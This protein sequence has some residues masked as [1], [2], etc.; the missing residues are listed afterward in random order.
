MVG[1]LRFHGTFQRYFDYIVTGNCPFYKIRPVAGQPRPWEAIG[2]WRVAPT[3]TRAMGRPKTPLTSLPSKG[4]HGEGTAPTSRQFNF[5][6]IF[7]NDSNAVWKLC[8]RTFDSDCF[9][10][11]E[12]YELTKFWTLQAFKG[13]KA[14]SFRKCRFLIFVISPTSAILKRSTVR[15]LWDF[16]DLKAISV[17]GSNAKPSKSV[18]RRTL[19]DFDVERSELSTSNALRYRRRTLRDFDVERSEISTSNAQRFRRGKLIDF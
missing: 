5:R 19:C 4:S 16:I 14:R 17:E 15:Q 2:F 13:L 18:R 6:Y 7:V 8:V 1:W 11:F 3:P 9:Q 10:I 12:I